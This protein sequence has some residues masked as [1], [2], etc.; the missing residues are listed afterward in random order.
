MLINLN[1]I[2]SKV[3]EHRIFEYYFGEEIIFNT[4]KYKNPMR[5]DRKG[6]CYFFINEN[7]RVFFIDPARTKDYNF[8]CWKFIMW[9]F[10]LTFSEALQKVNEDLSLNADEYDGAIVIGEKSIKLNSD[11]FKD[12][13]SKKK[14]QESVKYEISTRAYDENDLNYWNQ[15]N[16]DYEVLNYFNVIPVNII[17]KQSKNDSKFKIKYYHRTIDPC[18]AYKFTKDGKDYFKFYRPLND[19][20]KWEGNVNNTFVFGYDFLPKN[21]ELLFIV[22]G[23]KDLMCMK[24]MGF[25]SIAF[26]SESIT[27][28]DFIIKDLKT[29]FK[30]I[31]FLYDRDLTGIKCSIKYSIK[32]KCNLMILPNDMKI[33]KSLKDIADYVKLFGVNKTKELINLLLKPK[34]GKRKCKCRRSFKKSTSSFKSINNRFKTTRSIREDVKYSYFTH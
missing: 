31:Y 12:I 21:G 17:R 11:Q 7:N 8:D 14:N 25:N 34:Y 24:Q 30:N 29:R 4:P 22:S 9:K 18:Y 2:K 23:M 3:S 16:I 20:S 27:P 13:I 28:N 6:T 33:D 15:F 5:V 19:W 26:Q 32:F 10:N 1:S